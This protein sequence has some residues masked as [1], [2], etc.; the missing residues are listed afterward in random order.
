VLPVQAGGASLFGPMPQESLD[1]AILTYVARV[2][3]VPPSRGSK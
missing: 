1:E 3:N 2:K